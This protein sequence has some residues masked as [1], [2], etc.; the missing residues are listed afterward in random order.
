MNKQAANAIETCQ[1][2]Y[3]PFTPAARQPIPCASCHY[4]ACTRCVK[5]F[6]LSALVEPHCM[7]CR[8]Y[9]DRAFISDH[10]THSWCEG[11][12]RHHREAILFDRERSLLP[13]TQPDV[14]LEREKRTLASTLPALTTRIRYLKEQLAEAEGQVDAV[15][16]FIRHGR[17]I[18]DDNGSQKERRQFVAACPSTTCRGFLSNAYKCGT[19]DVQF[20]ADCREVR[21]EDHRCEPDLVATMRAIAKD[22]RPCPT[23]GT[24]ISRVSGCDQMFCTQCDT[25]FSYATGKKVVGVIHNP[26]Y[27]ERMRTRND[28]GEL[29]RQPGDQVCGGWPI[30]NQMPYPIVTNN[31]TFQ[32]LFRAAT[33]IQDT[34]LNQELR[35]DNTDL[36]VRYLLN[37]LDEAR[38][39]RL[40]QQRDRIY[41][42]RVEIR[43]VLQLFVITM[44]EMF[45][46]LHQN[47]IK[48]KTDDSV[49]PILSRHITFVDEMVNAP[50]RF[51]GDRYRNTVPQ[52]DYTPKV[53]ETDYRTPPFAERGYIP[54]KTSRRTTN[55]TSSSSDS[56]SSD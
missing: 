14:A 23:C 30:W 43:A 3:D 54:P 56:E 42:R 37:D 8:H 35:N 16:H 53:R 34:V 2:C 31:R 5:S 26:H 17:H 32:R 28:G 47:K 29:P 33:H 24:A 39:K 44:L 10:L 25:A 50:L 52:I 15:R 9:W 12:L 41:Q 48:Y 21:T 1:V 11:E 27:Y 40:V 7:N 46:D 18:N 36:R 51:I 4:V 20:C 13:A 22:S 6:L 45:I 55:T 49:A 19:C 38:F